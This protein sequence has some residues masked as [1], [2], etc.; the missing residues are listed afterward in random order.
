MLKTSVGTDRTV[1]SVKVTVWIPQ[2]LA[3]LKLVE[4]LAARV[5]TFGRQRSVGQD[6]VLELGHDRRRV[7]IMTP[8]P[9]PS[10][11]LTHVEH[12]ICTIVRATC[13]YHDIVSLPGYDTPTHLP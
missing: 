7:A 12:M 2:Q 3:E 4:S 8:P 6:G 10:A 11:L 5:L 9:R 1:S 13:H